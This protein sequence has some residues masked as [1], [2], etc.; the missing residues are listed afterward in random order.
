LISL[1]RGS[2]GVFAPAGQWKG[3]FGAPGAIHLHFASEE[4]AASDRPR[5]AA[6][7]PDRVRRFALEPTGL[8]ELPAVE[9]LAGVH[10]FVSW[11]PPE[12]GEGTLVAVSPAGL[13][14]LGADGKEK[15]RHAGSFRPT[16]CPPSSTA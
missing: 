9:G 3:D 15:W 11:V 8:K 4:D 1:H 10:A 2:A 5:L 16:P 13:V 14:A 6:A 12:G 7:A